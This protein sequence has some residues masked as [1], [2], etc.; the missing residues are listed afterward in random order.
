MTVRTLSGRSQDLLDTEFEDLYQ[1]AVLETANQRLFTTARPYRTTATD[2]FGNTV[3]DFAHASLHI[4]EFQT[5]QGE[6]DERPVDAG[7]WTGVYPMSIRRIGTKLFI[8]SK[9][10]GGRNRIYSLEEGR[11][12]DELNGKLK[13]VSYRLYTRGFTFNDLDSMKDL[14][15]H[16]YE[17]CYSGDWEQQYH[18]L[19][20][21]CDNPIPLNIETSLSSDRCIDGGACLVTTEGIGN[22]LDNYNPGVGFSDEDRCNKFFRSIQLIITG[23]ARTFELYRLSLE[24][25]RTAENILKSEVPKETFIERDCDFVHD[26]NVYSLPERLDFIR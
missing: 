14:Y 23:T 26:L 18:I 15:S 24:A 6:E 2:S 1:Y 25:N 7:I 5:K 19:K 8:I 10:P 17:V 21:E 9:D 4:M 12:Y 3:E 13:Q 11:D 20:N 22:Y 16:N